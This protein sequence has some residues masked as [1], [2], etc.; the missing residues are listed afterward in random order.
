MGLY[1]G[2]R[3]GVAARA[4]FES[5]EQENTHTMK[6]PGDICVGKFFVGN[7]FVACGVVDRSEIDGCA[8]ERARERDRF[9]RTALTK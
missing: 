4:L 5:V 3:Q 1:S 9:S 7:E 6:S 8:R 2:D